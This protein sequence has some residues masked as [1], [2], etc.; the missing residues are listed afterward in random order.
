ML[1]VLET[2]PRWLE[3]RGAEEGAVAGER[4]EGAAPDLEETLVSAGNASPLAQLFLF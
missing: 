3:S 4:G 1:G 2:D